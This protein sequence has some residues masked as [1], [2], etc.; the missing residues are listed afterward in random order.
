MNFLKKYWYLLTLIIITI[1]LGA[2]TYFTS[3]KLSSSK[4][5]APNVPQEKPQAAEE[6]C[7]LRFSINGT[8]PSPSPTTPETSVTPSVTTTPNPSGTP[9]PTLTNTPTPTVTPTGTPRPTNTPVPTNTPQATATPRP[10]CNTA[11]TESGNECAS[12]GS[13]Y[14]CYQGTCRLAT[15]PERSN[16]SCVTITQTTPQVPVSGS[17]AI[18][19]IIAVIGGILLLVFGLAL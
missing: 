17:P 14:S 6:A 16:C 8:S 2:V 13:A 12:L 15:C 5:V 19:G 4:P 7:I 18:I 3:Q 1:G 11:C 10:G 9:T